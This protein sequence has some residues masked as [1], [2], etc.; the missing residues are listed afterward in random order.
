MFNRLQLK[1]V[2]RQLLVI[3]GVLL[4][5]RFTKN[6]GFV[7]V[8]LYGV[9]CCL[10]RDIGRALVVF[11]LLS[12]LPMVNPF[13]M[14]RYGQ[15]AMIARLSSLLMALAL[16]FSG[17]DRP[18]PHRLPLDLLFLYL[19]VAAFSSLQ[20]YAP[21]VSELKI[22]NFTFLLLAIAIGTRNL[23]RN[24]ADIQL[25]RNTYL[26]VIAFTVYGSLLT[27]PFPH[28][29]YLTSLRNIMVNWGMEYAYDVATS[30]QSLLFCGATAHSQFL[31]PMSACCLG[32][33]LCDMWLVEKRWNLLHVALLIPIPFICF[34]TRARIGLL[35]L[36]VAVFANVFICL[37]RTNLPRRTNNKFYGSVI[38]LLVA[39]L[40]TAL[41]S[42]FTNRAISRWMRKTD[43][44]SSDDRTLGD[45]FTQSR[46]GAIATNLADFRRNRLFGSGF[47]VARKMLGQKRSSSS[48][49]SAPIEKGLLPLMVLG[50][51]GLLGASIF[52]LFLVVF[53]STCHRKRYTAT[54]ILFIVF[55][56]TNLAEATFFSPSGGGGVYWSLM[57][58]G[59]FTIDMAVVVS[60][61][62]TPEALFHPIPN[63]DYASDEDH[64]E[65]FLEMEAPPDI[66]TPPTENV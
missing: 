52:I 44:V 55:L 14:P 19:F 25:L 15:F 31:G 32:W 40:S 1:Q 47:Q 65:P 56:T 51:S 41:V 33:L 62:S 39:L 34:M 9:S 16:L 54:A 4:L 63:L 6:W 22:V 3:C 61:R 59:G 17:I 18:G 46:Q 49:F 13:I 42:E 38:L 5:S 57:V 66:E 37:P 7:F 24:P 48:L 64:T 27:L 20:G 21:L 36:A 28:I 53:F 30:G 10:R 60:R 8:A 12:F 11:L 45:A 29:A 26:A 58:V 50:E 23:H 35:S 43:D 2:F